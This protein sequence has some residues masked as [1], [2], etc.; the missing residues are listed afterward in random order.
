MA[1][2]RRVSRA[3]VNIEWIETHCVI[4]EGKFVGQSVKLRP[5][6]RKMI[7]GIYGKDTRRAII[8]MGRK[9]AKTGMA[10]FLL[11]LHLCGPEY[12]VNSELYSAAM[13]REQAAKLFDMARKMVLMSSTLRDF[14]QIRD[15][16]K[17]LLCPELGTK[18]KAL[19]AEA[20]T[21][22]GLS[23]VFVVHDELGQVKGPRSALY[24]ALETAVGAQESPL[25][26][27]ISTQAPTGADLLSVLIDDAKTQKDPRVRLFVY[28]ADPDADPFRRSTIRQANPA[29]GDFLNAD[30]VMAMAE[31]AR[32]MP[33]KEADYRNLVLNQRVESSNPFVTPSVWNDNAGEP[34]VDWV[35]H[36]VFAGLDLSEV[37]DLTA[38]VLVCPIDGVLHVRPRFWLPADGLRERSLQDR[39]PYDVWADQGF[40]NT[41]PGNSIQYEHVAEYIVG[42]FDEYDLRKIAFD[43]WNMKHL[44]P[45]MNKAGLEEDFIE[46]H[47]EDFGQGYKSMSPALRSLEGMLLEKQV[48]HGGHPVL[49]MCAANSVVQRDP[50]GNRKLDKLRS[51]GRIDGMVSLAMA[52]SLAAADLGK[53]KE[54]KPFVMWV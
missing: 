12:K 37:N 42:L 50:A 36:P 11:L 7:R 1:L 22:Y 29:F 26:V 17:E 14:V 31:D 25:S 5:W 49:T 34:L 44:I 52:A 51:R 40:L 46:E 24:E 20:S 30:E 28:E 38:L 21:A 54:T 32:R 19:S 41:T 9:N 39:V 45:W 23:P 48:R 35:G 53:P 47:F 16:A 10:A 43:R 27:I 15:T 33:S 18:Y 13:S 2:K 4:P 8:T 3:T 6:Q